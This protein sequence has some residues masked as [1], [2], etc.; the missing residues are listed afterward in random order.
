MQRRK[1]NKANA[2]THSSPST[3]VYWVPMG[4]DWDVNRGPSG[5][6]DRYPIAF[7]TGAQVGTDWEKPIGDE[8]DPNG[9]RR[10]PNRTPGK[11]RSEI[12]RDLN[13]NCRDIPP[14]PPPRPGSN[15]L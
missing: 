9:P 15:G 7:V 12:E 1:K 3:T 5:I 13:I 14:Q 6:A 4:V 2:S 11:Y 10:I 8:G